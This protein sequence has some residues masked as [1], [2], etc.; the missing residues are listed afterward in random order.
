MNIRDR[1]E[2][3]V[4]PCLITGCWLWTDAP[5]RY[6]YG[7]LGVGKRAMKA[8]RLSYECY[9]GPIPDGLCVCHRCDT[10]SC[11]NPQH[12]FLGTP[13]ENT[14]DMTAKGRRRQVAPYNPCR[15]RGKPGSR[16]NDDVVAQLRARVAAGEKLHQ[17]NE[18]RRLGVVQSVLSRAIR[19]VTWKHVA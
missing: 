7:R 14:A 12:L 1:I 9:R 15:G 2:R 10:P 16:L 13:A 3:K 17:G 6:G 19:G 5:D 11:V 4:E 8:H 18:A